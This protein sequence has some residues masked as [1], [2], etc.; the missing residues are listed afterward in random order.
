MMPSRREASG[1]DPIN[2]VVA[3]LRPLCHFVF[4]QSQVVEQARHRTVVK[5]PG[6]SPPLRGDRADENENKEQ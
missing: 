2:Q 5:A 3:D 4:E 1:E 6:A